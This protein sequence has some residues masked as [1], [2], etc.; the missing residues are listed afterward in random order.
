V[1]FCCV[2]AEWTTFVQ[3]AKAGE[4]VEPRFCRREVE[5]YLRCGILGHGF[6]RVHCAACRRSGATFVQRAK[7]GERVE[8][9]FCRREVEGYLRCGIL[10][11]GFARV[12][13]A[14]CKKDR[15]VAFSCKGRRLCPPCGTRRILAKPAWLVDR[16][17]PKVP[18]RQWVLPLPYRMLHLCAY[19]ADLCPGT[20]P[21]P[22]ASGVGLLRT[23]RTQPGEIAAAGWRLNLLQQV[24]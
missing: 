22:S 20:A 3:R 12:R 24:S 4:R 23:A 16:V 14:A 15:V 13:C 19:D 8:P 10:G 2:Q 21:D 9:R 6:A 17:I 5:E 1:L 11:H 7:A 18:V